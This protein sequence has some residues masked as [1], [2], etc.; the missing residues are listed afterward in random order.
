M[1]RTTFL[2][3]LLLSAAALS[4]TTSATAAEVSQLDESLVKVEDRAVKTRNEALKQ[5]LQNV[6]L[7]NSGSQSALMAPSIAS[8][9]NKPTSLI[10]Q[11][12]YKEIDGQQY[13][14]AS[15]D[16]QKIIRLLRDAQLPVWGKQ[17]PLT[18]IWLSL[19]ADGSRRILND[20][21]TDESR[22]TITATANQRGL[23]VLLPLMDLDDAM[24]I[25]AN[26]VRGMFNDVVASASQRYNTD[27]FVMASIEPS[28][29]GLV[30]Y[31]MALYP[32]VSN[33]PLFAPLIQDA[34]K[35]ADADSAMGAILLA[36]S[37]YYVGQY[38]VADS[39]EALQTQIT[40]IDITDRKQ[41]VDIEKY[42]QQL[43]AV[44]SVSLKTL[45]GVTA[46]F[47]LDLF[48]S[49]A[50]LQR[51]INLES[52]IRQQVVQRPIVNESLD[53]LAVSQTQSTNYIWLGN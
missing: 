49:E 41:L 22:Q 15:F 32:S 48:G 37:E 2:V 33:E 40:F 45:Q 42:L 24:V 14:H 44:K 9:I 35:V 26:D 43:S 13:L 39:G 17:R 16:H 53:P 31:N 25:A 20:S 11:Y 28:A 21:A 51:L 10:R 46:K 7:K 1:F 34:G 6:I 23:P 27:Y 4:V 38:A 36:L 52:K 18:L 50:D 3:S 5:A 30:N 19:D 12:G 8:S 29:D 47:S